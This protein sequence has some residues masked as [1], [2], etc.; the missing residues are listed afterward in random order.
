MSHFIVKCS[1]GTVINQYRCVG[2]K[3][4]TV[5]D[6]GCGKCHDKD[7]VELRKL[8]HTAG[9]YWEIEKSGDI[10]MVHYDD[11]K[12]LYSELHGLFHGDD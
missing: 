1:C 9:N 5:V 4:L 3:K 11:L 10:L 12:T 7:V 2:D 8:R 6:N